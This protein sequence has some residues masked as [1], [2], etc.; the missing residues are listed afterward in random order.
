MSGTR[1]AVA[2]EFTAK[3]R[4]TRDRI[5]A[6]A[7]D[8]VYENG[9]ANTSLHDVQQA[10]GVSGS[11]MYH[12]FPDK[13]LLVHAVVDRQREI[14]LA[15]QAQLLDHL[16][17]LEGIQAWCDHVVR[18]ARRRQGRSGCPIGSLASEL[19]DHDPVARAELAET[20][21]QW[22]GLIRD[23]L[24]A[25][26]DRGELSPE[27]DPEQLGYALFAATQGGLLIAQALRDTA[28]LELALDAVIDRIASLA[29]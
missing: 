9:V 1:E 21:Q 29:A 27:A 15:R 26:Q 5:V 4:A 12:Y 18:T 28:P 22:S 20:F 3:G 10:A 2:K 17:S 24:R 14:L 8:L 7:T 23:G 11:Q 13:T 6:E 16:D 19:S 25:M